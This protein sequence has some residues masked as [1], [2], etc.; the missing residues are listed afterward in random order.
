MGKLKWRELIRNL[1]K[2]NS[3]S[4]SETVGGVKKSE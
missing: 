1:R 2:D 3:P 4:R